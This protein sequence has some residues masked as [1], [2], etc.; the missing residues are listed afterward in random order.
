[1]KRELIEGLLFILIG[2]LLMFLGVLLIIYGFYDIQRIQ[3]SEGMNGLIMISDWFSTLGVVLIGS[4]FLTFFIGI[5][6]LK[7]SYHDDKTGARIK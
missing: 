1:M 2:L 4:G 6:I 3:A 5:G 7:G